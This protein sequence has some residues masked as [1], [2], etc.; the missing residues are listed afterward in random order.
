[1]PGMHGVLGYLAGGLL[2]VY[3]VAAAT[4]GDDFMDGGK[5]I[6]L[7]TD[8]FDEVLT[9]HRQALVLFYAPWYGRYTIRSFLSAP[10]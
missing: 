2:L 10:S 1:M 4:N 7:D 9:R 3:S 8:T 5:V 6:H